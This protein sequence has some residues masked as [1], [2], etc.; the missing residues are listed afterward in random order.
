M[1]YGVVFNQVSNEPIERAQNLHQGLLCRLLCARLLP[2]VLDQV[3]KSQVTPQ[4]AETRDAAV[5]K[6]AL[7]M[8]K[9]L[10]RGSFI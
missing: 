9:D 10:N 5:V 6:D 2:R 7:Q 4:G 8:S 3:N 1:V